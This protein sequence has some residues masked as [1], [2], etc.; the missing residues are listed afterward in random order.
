[1]SR[2]KQFTQADVVELDKRIANAEYDK[3]RFRRDLVILARSFPDGLGRV[4]ESCD[5][6]HAIFIDCLLF[7][8]LYPRYP[9]LDSVAVLAAY[10]IYRVKASVEGCGLGTEIYVIHQYRIGIVPFDLINRWESLF[11]RYDRLER[12]IFSHAMN[13]VMRPS[14]PAQLAGTHFT[15]PEMRPLQ[16]IVADIEA[17]R[18]E[19]NTLTILEILLPNAPEGV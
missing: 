10:V 18:A 2:A 12:E 4:P 15:E 1:L 9:T 13:F 3:L 17:M 19:F 16:Q 11:R 8:R 6:L 14:I 7:N 5:V